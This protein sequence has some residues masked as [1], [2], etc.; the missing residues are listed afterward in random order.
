MLGVDKALIRKKR[1]REGK[2]RESREGED[3]VVMNELVFRFV[4]WSFGI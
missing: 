4:K 3:F 2:G 1:E